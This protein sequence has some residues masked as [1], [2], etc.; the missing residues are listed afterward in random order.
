MT[1]KDEFNAAAN[2]MIPIENPEDEPDDMTSSAQPIITVQLS[3]P[4]I[5]QTYILR[6]VVTT[7]IARNPKYDTKVVPW[8]YRAGA[9]GK[10]IDIVVAQVM[11]RSGSHPILYFNS[12]PMADE[13]DGATFHTVEIMQAVRVSEEEEPDDTKLYSA[14]KLAA[15]EMLKYV[16]QP[17]SGLRPKSNG[18]VEPIQLKHQR[19]TNILGYELA[20]GRFH[21]G[22][23]NTVFVPE[24]PL[25]PDQAGDD[26]IIEGIGNL[27]VAM[28][29]EEEE[30]NLNKLTIRDTEPGEILQNW[31][32]SSSIFQ[33]ESR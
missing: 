9:K 23:S 21:Q 31:T 26:H 14:A 15:S 19:G 20:S 27:F 6:V 5:F 1:D 17:K 32:I 13:L 11:T 2:I 4:L 7:L 28:A 33:P 12:I 18:I 10:T 24:K 8:D 3:D 22:K 29:G 25:I 16:Y 30:I